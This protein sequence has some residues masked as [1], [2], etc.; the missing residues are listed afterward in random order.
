[1]KLPML[2][3]FPFGRYLENAAPGEEEGL[4]GRGGL[5]ETEGR[6]VEVRGRHEPPPPAQQGEN[7]LDN[8]H[9]GQVE[10]RKLQGGCPEGHPPEKEESKRG[11]EENHPG[12][13]EHEVVHGGVVAEA[14]AQAKALPEKGVGPPPG[15][16]CAVGPAQ[17]RG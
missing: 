17:S 11:Q 15:L 1:M 6:L 3:P 5:K 7:R 4:E 12:P 8:D 2:T 10:D 9:L 14:L 13:A 16:K